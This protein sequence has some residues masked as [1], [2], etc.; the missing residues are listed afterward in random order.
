MAAMGMYQQRKLEHVRQHLSGVSKSAYLAGILE[1]IFA[2]RMSTQDQVES[3][4]RFVQ[5]A[6]WHNPLECPFEADGRTLV[7]DACE[8]LELHDA[9]CW[10]TAEV[11]RALCA[12]AGWKARV[13]FLPD[14][15]SDSVHVIT[16]TLLDG[17]WVVLDANYFK[18]GVILR[19]PD[20]SLPTLEW[21]RQNP[22]Y[23]DSLP[24]GW[25]FPAH[26]LIN[27]AGIPVHGQFALPFADAA[28]TWG[29]E[30]RYASYLGGECWYPPSRPTRLRAERAGPRR[31]RVSWQPSQSRSARDICYEVR[32][33]RNGGRWETAQ[34]TA[35]TNLMI[36]DIE[37]ETPFEVSVAAQDEQRPQSPRPWY[38]A[39]SAAFNLAAC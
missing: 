32:L 16:E 4:V 36:D 30:A 26:Y 24:G 25:I 8:L 12:A 10:H 11:V 23:P 6:T 13:T 35:S 7:L 14:D 5:R 19:R 17:A 33:R 22:G 27:A 37:A 39:R 3:L 1:T 34:E 21:L 18:N 28:D 29:A 38:P 15:Y 31:V 2:R 9:R 20:G